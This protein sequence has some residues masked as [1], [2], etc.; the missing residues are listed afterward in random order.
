MFCCLSNVFYS[1]LIEFKTTTFTL[2]QKSF[3]KPRKTLILTQQLHFI[4]IYWFSLY[5]G[6]VLTST[7]FFRFHLYSTLGVFALNR[8]MCVTCSS[9]TSPTDSRWN[10]T[11]TTSSKSRTVASCPWRGRMFW[12]HGCGSSSSRRKGW[13]TAAWPESGSSSYLRRCSILTTACLNTLPRKS[14]PRCTELLLIEEM[15]EPIY[16][17]WHRT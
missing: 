4:T 8:V 3:F 6:H 12:R 7:H 5:K 10:C 14:L 9:L 13:T 17:K 16:R 15:F 2:G 11:G 1:L